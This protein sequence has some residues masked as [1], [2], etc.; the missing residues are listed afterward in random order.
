VDYLQTI[1]AAGL[2]LTKARQAVVAALTEAKEPLT[3]A[4]IYER[5][6]KRADLVSVY[7]TVERLEALGLL[8]R[9]QQGAHAVFAL[10]DRHHHHIVCRSC[11]QQ[12]CLPCDVTVPIPKGFS[13]VQHAV[14][15]TGLCANC[16]H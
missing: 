13:A 10:A 16:A 5:L 15:L 1:R 4:E 8:T 14:S 2:R 7:R 12:A 3:V 11:E 6:G 9:E